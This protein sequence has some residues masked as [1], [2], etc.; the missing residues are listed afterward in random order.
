M[1]L[2]RASHQLRALWPFPAVRPRPAPVNI[3][4]GCPHSE[5]ALGV[6]HQER[7]RGIEMV[8]QSAKNLVKRLIR[9][10]VQRLP[11]GAK[12][13]AFRELCQGQSALDAFYTSAA[14]LNVVGVS[15]RGEYGTISHSMADRIILPAYAGTG[16]WAIDTNERL[17]TFF[18]AGSWDVRRRRRRHR[19]HNDTGRTEPECRLNSHR[20]GSVKFQ[21][22][23][24]QH[25]R[26]LPHQNVKLHQLA[27]FSE[28][29]KLQF[30]LSPYNLGDHRIKLTDADGRDNE[31]KRRTIE[32]DAVALDDLITPKSMPMQSKLMPKGQNLSSLRGAPSSWL[33]QTSDNGNLALRHCPHGREPRAN[34]YASAGQFR[35]RSTAFSRRF[36]CR[37]HDFKS[38][39]TR[40]ASGDGAEG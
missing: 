31:Q 21:L 24:T 12:R 6:F 2:R 27:A 25:H 20:A 1:T 30:E 35:H 37:T 36:C 39:L 4:C 26:Q 23:V 29:K 11:V 38:G 17:I 14:A 8:P 18:A 32:V 40:A 34:C 10:S 19:A 28:R 16:R 3:P 33:A 13:V 22:S 7:R 5:K 9:Y 15:V